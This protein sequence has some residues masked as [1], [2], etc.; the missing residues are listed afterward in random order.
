MWYLCVSFVVVFVTS[1]RLYIVDGVSEEVGA[2]S[3]IS[4]NFEGVAMS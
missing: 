2:E 4:H 3:S 1:F